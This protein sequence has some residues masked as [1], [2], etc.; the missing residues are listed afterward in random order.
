MSNIL[1][2]DDNAQ[3]LYLAR[4][5]L[6]QAGHQIDEVE[7]GA[8]AVEAVHYKNYD[9][10]LMDIQ[11]P[12]LDGLSAIRQILTEIKS[13]PPIVALSAKVMVGDRDVFLAAGCDGFIEKPI[14]ADDFAVNI[15][16][17]LENK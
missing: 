14:S 8:L 16:R 13:P 12:V 7:N 6:E 10:I 3:N 2:A 11:M 5:L 15:G 4:Y 17:Y 9:L 1:I